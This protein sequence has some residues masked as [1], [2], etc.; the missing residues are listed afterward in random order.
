MTI[1]KGRPT[2]ETLKDLLGAPYYMDPLQIK[3]IEVEGRFS[4]VY[5]CGP[6]AFED[7][8]RQ[9]L[10]AIGIQE[11]M[12]FSENFGSQQEKPPLDT[13]EVRLLRSKHKL[14]WQRRKPLLQH[15][16]SDSPIPNGEALKLGRED[17]TADST[18]LDEMGPSILE[19]AEQAGLTPD[20]GCRVGSCGSCEAALK[21][22]KVAGGMQIGGTV[23]VCVAR[24]ASEVL[25][26]DL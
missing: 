18:E 25:E 2:L 11:S 7:T 19:L 3:P 24:P 10:S 8:M 16:H 4:T 12:I 17:G 15:S 23:R 21:C 22:G 1:H 5:L 20:Y 6:V 13:A 26:F 14:V 9:F